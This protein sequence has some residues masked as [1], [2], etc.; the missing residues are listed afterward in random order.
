MRNYKITLHWSASRYFGRVTYDNSIIWLSLG[1]ANGV[2]LQCV[3]EL[4]I[5]IENK[6][7]TK[8]RELAVR[9]TSQTQR[10]RTISIEKSELQ[11]ENKFRGFL[12]D[13][14]VF[15]SWQNHLKEI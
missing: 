1:L 9:I 8:Y 7:W 2:L 6:M 5:S 12:V 14:P 11:N 4:Q 10:G 13:E 15:P 3:V